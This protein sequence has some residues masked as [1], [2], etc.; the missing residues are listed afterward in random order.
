[1]GLMLSIGFF[2]FLKTF[3][4]LAV[5]YYPN[6]S[7]AWWTH[8]PYI[9]TAHNHRRAFFLYVPIS[10]SGKYFFNFCALLGGLSRPQFFQSVVAA[11]ASHLCI[12]SK[13]IN[14]QL[15]HLF[16]K[17]AKTPKTVSG[18][19]LKKCKIAGSDFQSIFEKMH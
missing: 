16:S 3:R 12:N 11:A 2:T 7:G 8:I 17:N 18:T 13:N 9:L 14:A 15:W 6:N 10:L 19:F 5:Y 1:M 4:F